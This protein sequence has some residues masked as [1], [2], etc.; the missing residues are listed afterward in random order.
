MLTAF[1]FRVWV[2]LAHSD[3]LLWCLEHSSHREKP[4]CRDLQRVI[5]WWSHD[6]YWQGRYW[7]RRNWSQRE[8]WTNRISHSESVKS[9]NQLR[10]CWIFSSVLH[11]FRRSIIISVKWY[12][13]N[14]SSSSRSSQDVNRLSFSAIS[15]LFWCVSFFTTVGE[16]S[17]NREE[18][19]P[20]KNYHVYNSLI[21]TCSRSSFTHKQ[22]SRKACDALHIFLSLSRVPAAAR[23]TTD[24][25]EKK[26]SK[27][28]REVWKMY[29]VT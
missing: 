15:T 16:S 23:Y 29:L 10:Q 12:L 14:P 18:N 3:M 22:L 25:L 5:S 13:M 28:T 27:W 17:S 26:T 8:I 19:Y 2:I 7:M 4:S 1:W 9:I 6:V 21:Y 20:F 11:F 24:Q